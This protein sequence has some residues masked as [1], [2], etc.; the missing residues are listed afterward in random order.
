MKCRE[1][2]PQVTVARKIGI[3]KR[4]KKL[5]ERA[6]FRKCFNAFKFVAQ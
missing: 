3:E 6:K 4:E 5:K 1:W 2:A